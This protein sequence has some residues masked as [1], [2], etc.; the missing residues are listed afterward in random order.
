MKTVR[1][2]SGFY[3]SLDGRVLIRR[4]GAGYYQS[5]WMVT[6]DGKEMPSRHRTR[7]NAVQ[8]AARLLEVKS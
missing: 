8:W 1:V 3:R 4:H 7:R 2:Y 5:H 6:L